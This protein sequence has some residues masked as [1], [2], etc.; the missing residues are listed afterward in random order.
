MISIAVCLGIALLAI[1]IF[2]I[3]IKK[4]IRK[5]FNFV[6]N[7]KINQALAEYYKDENPEEEEQVVEEVPEKK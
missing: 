3:L 7:D 5:K 4:R 1:L 2:Y 6:L